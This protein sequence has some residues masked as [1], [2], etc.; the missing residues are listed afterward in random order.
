MLQGWNDQR[1]VLE[2]LK[3]NDEAETEKNILY[4]R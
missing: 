2:R 1:P 4:H 3:Q